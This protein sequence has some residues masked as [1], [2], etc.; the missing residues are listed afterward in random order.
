[1]IRYLS[2]A[3]L[4]LLLPAI[5]HAYERTPI[6]AANQPIDGTCLYWKPRTLRWHP[7]QM[8]DGSAPQADLVQVVRNSFAAWEAPD[9]TDLAFQEGSLVPR[10]VGY[11]PNGS[12]ANVVVFHDMRC[13]D[14]PDSDPCHLEF[15]C[16]CWNFPQRMIAVTTTTFRQCT[17]EIV[18]A[19]I[20]MNGA[21]FRLTWVDGPTCAEV[22]DACGS[23]CS[24]EDLRGCVETDVENTLVHEIGHLIGLDHSQ[25]R[26]ATM[27]AEAAR[28]ETSKRSLH[29]DDVAGVCD[30]Y[31]AGRK[32]WICEPA[33][34]PQCEGHGQSGLTQPSGIGCAAGGGGGAVSLW[35]AA[36][37]GWWGW[38]RRRGGGVEDLA[39][40]DGGRDRPGDPDGRRGL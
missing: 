33:D 14:I 7:T 9:C 10:V 37:L 22:E 17:G 23:S 5:A 29:R 34:I 18:D 1:M 15:S 26:D 4:L 8:P 20:E 25:E 24:E 19:D 39:V 38:R 6:T 28:G 40:V 35:V 16:D 32:T 2:A 27:Y 31:P 12:N 30:I 11:D 21:D 13:D 3:A 36:A